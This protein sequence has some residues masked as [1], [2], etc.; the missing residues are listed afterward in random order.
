[1]DKNLFAVRVVKG[2]ES[3]DLLQFL[4]FL[5][6]IEGTDDDSAAEAGFMILLANRELDNRRHGIEER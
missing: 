4:H 3:D 1:M 5:E 6:Q 2:L